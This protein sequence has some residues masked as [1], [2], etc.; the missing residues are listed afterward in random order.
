MTDSAD[1]VVALRLI[2]AS[3]DPDAEKEARSH[4]I[5]VIADEVGHS[6][7]RWREIAIRTARVA[8]LFASMASRASDPDDARVKAQ[9]AVERLLAGALKPGTN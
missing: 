8:A 4:S 5:E 7:E 3:L 9:S 1:G 6:P 2:L